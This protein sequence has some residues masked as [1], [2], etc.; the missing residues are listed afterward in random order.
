MSL[1]LCHAVVFIAI[2]FSRTPLPPPSPAPSASTVTG[3]GG[4]DPWASPGVRVAGRPFHTDPD[5]RLL[6]LADLPVAIVTAAAMDVVPRSTDPQSR[7]AESYWFAALWF[8]SGTAQWWLIGTAGMFFQMRRLFRSLIMTLALILTC[9]YASAFLS[10]VD[11]EDRVAHDVAKWARQPGLY[12]D[13]GSANASSTILSRAHVATRA[14]DHVSVRECRPMASIDNAR[15][16]APFLVS[17]AW[18]FS[19]TPKD[20]AGGRRRFLCILGVVIELTPID[21]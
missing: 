7:V 1:A 21:A 4:I 12:V 5:F 13:P 15:I 18:G 20:G 3:Q 6:S 2:I 9:G 19:G 14:C 8:L 17:V 16:V 11:C 10:R